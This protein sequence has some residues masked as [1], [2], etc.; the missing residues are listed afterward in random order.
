M[1]YQCTSLLPRSKPV[2]ENYLHFF[3]DIKQ[4]NA[5]YRL[6][7]L[8]L[9]VKMFLMEIILPPFC[10]KISNQTMHSKGSLANITSENAFKAD[11]FS[12]EGNHEYRNS[13]KTLFLVF[14]QICVVCFHPYTAKYVYQGF[15]SILLLLQFS[16]HLLLFLEAK[17]KIVTPCAKFRAK[18]ASTNGVS[19]HQ[20]APAKQTNTA[21]YHLIFKDFEPKSVLYKL[22][23]LILPV[24]ML[25][26]EITLG[27][28]VTMNIRTTKKPCFGYCCRFLT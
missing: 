14:L 3:K 18:R 1:V 2:Q 9:L 17:H 26:M 7:R 8:R 27:V 24:K 13:K 23:R 22:M 12:G 6:I 5:L 21:N 11:H 25:L 10:Q 20:F 4:K 16:G 15:S 28:K 19:M